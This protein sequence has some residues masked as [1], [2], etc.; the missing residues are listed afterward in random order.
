MYP[1]TLYKGIRIICQMSGEIHSV[2]T[3]KQPRQANS[4]E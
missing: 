3:E 2:E 1:V 4:W